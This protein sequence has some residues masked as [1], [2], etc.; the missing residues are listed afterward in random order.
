MGWRWSI[1]KTAEPLYM[2]VTV[3]QWRALLE[4][5]QIFCNVYFLSL[6]FCLCT[7]SQTIYCTLAVCLFVYP[8]ARGSTLFVVMWCQCKR[9]MKFGTCMFSKPLVLSSFY[10]QLD[11]YSLRGHY[12]YSMYITPPNDI[13]WQTLPFFRKLLADAFKVRCTQQN[14]VHTITTTTKKKR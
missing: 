5:K 6:P 14:W 11:E 7:P 10:F 3:R 13:S 12:R 9:S 4:C 1:T 2:I 8:E